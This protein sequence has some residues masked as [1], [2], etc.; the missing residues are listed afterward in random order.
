M[1]WQKRETIKSNNPYSI[2]K[3]NCVLRLIKKPP[4]SGFVH[5]SLHGILPVICR[6]RYM[7]K[8]IEF[9]ISLV[10]L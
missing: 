10:K 2:S 8:S 3:T 7:A 4:R 9:N 1:I 5:H 6:H